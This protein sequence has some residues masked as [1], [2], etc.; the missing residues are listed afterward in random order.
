MK[1]LTANTT[2]AAFEKHIPEVEVNGNVVTVKVGSVEHP[3][4]P[5]HHIAHIWLETTEG[6]QRKDLDP[7]G[8]PEAVFALAGDSPLYIFAED[9]STFSKKMG[10]CRDFEKT[11]EGILYKDS[12]ALIRDIAEG[13]YN[14]E[15]SLLIKKTFLSDDAGK[16]S[17]VLFDHIKNLSHGGN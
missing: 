3:M 16:N 13:I 14:R 17:E 1:E 7:T 15:A 5:E 8:K 11:Y 2:E 4:I 9:I 10:V 12:T 6:V